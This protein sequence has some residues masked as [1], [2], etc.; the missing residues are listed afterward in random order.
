MDLPLGLYRFHRLQQG[1]NRTNRDSKSVCATHFVCVGGQRR[2]GEAKIIK[3]TNKMIL[4][5]W[6]QIVAENILSAATT[7]GAQSRAGT[8]SV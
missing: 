1:Q 7:D 2:A 5:L 4:V 6:L 3:S 8:G